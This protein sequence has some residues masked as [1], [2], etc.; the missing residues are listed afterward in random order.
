MPETS[1]GGAI[2]TTKLAVTAVKNITRNMRR[3][4]LSAVAIA[5]AAMSIVLL[6]A[7]I[8]EMSNDMA[9]NLKTYY[10]GAVRVRHADYDTYE[11]YNPIHLTVDWEQAKQ[12]IGQVDGI[13]AFTPRIT[14]PANLYIEGSN[15]A[16]MGVGADFDSEKKYHDIE[17][18][19]KVGR[20]PEAGENEMIMGA[21]L[22]RDL[23][24]ET[25][26]E[27]TILSTTAARGTNA[28]T[29]EIVG[30]AA[31]PVGSLNASNFWAPLDRIQHFLRMDG[32]VKDILIDTSA[33][34]DE[35]EV[36]SAV[37]AALFEATGTEHDVRSWKEL[38]E[39][40]SFIELAEVIY[41]FIAVFF[42]LLGSTVIINTT[43]MVIFE[44]MREIGTLSA[45][46][47]HGRELVSL[48]FLEGT[49]IAI[50]GSLVGVF[51]GVGITAYLGEVG[52]NFTDA[53]QGIDIEISSILYPVLDVPLTIF[54]FFY[55]VAIAA[56]ATLIP[57]RKAAK[58]E[59]VE[60]L[61]YI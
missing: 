34:A 55:S 23:N 19:L 2:M 32:Q 38:S 27:V 51:L 42:F 54:I 6:F 11:R 45:L 46:G 33:D 53:M 20:L 31:F 60:A 47:M 57:S 37:D 28:I 7:L 48:F 26:D 50:V 61:R 13:R 4:I 10:S 36:A 59:P 41:R 29:L 15:F 18:V 8:G 12:A 14:F 43:M 52:I 58:I 49:F 30:L 44:R 17:S 25:G 1:V 21:V 24:L 3:S 35:K 16:A 40:Y 56:F 39:M 22:A 5:V 9:T